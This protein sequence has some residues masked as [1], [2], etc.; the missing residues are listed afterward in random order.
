L[1][2]H[3]FSPR[4]FSFHPLLQDATNHRSLWRFSRRAGFLFVLVP[5]F[6]SGGVVS[7]I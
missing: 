3:P 5:S 1:F 6:F 2:V 4:F 7:A